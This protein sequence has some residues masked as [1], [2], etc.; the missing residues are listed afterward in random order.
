MC[1][2]SRSVAQGDFEY[3]FVGELDASRAINKNHQGDAEVTAY[4]AETRHILSVPVGTLS[5]PYC[6]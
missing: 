3:V 2:A 5:S 4:S 6:T 1:F